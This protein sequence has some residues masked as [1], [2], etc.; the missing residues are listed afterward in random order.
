MNY[1][2]YKSTWTSPLTV[3]V[4]LKFSVKFANQSRCIGLTNWTKHFIQWWKS[5]CKFSY[6]R[7]THFDKAVFDRLYIIII[8]KNMFKAHFLTCQ[9]IRKLP[10]IADFS[11]QVRNSTK[12]FYSKREEN[13]THEKKK[14]TIQHNKLQMP[15]SNF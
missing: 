8:Y 2:S 7:E 9:Q 1:T 10:Y 11:V 3:V 13:E 12:K 6:P 5:Y 15:N 4:Q 14:P